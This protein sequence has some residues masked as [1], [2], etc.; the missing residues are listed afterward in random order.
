MHI[1]GFSGDEET[2]LDDLVQHAAIFGTGGSGKTGLSIAIAEEA[3]LAGVPV[4]AID[5]HGDLSNL[6]LVFE[7]L[8]GE[9]I[10]E[11]IE[12]LAYDS[13]DEAAA[14]W[15]SALEAEHLDARLPQLCK[16]PRLI[17]TPA[18]SAGVPLNTVAS[19]AAPAH[20]D[21]DLEADIMLNGL[22][23]LVGLEPEMTSPEYAVCSQ[24]LQ[25]NWALGKSVDLEKLIVQLID[26]PFVKSGT[27][28]VDSFFPPARRRKLAFAFNGLLASISY[29]NLSSGRGFDPEEIL[30]SVGSPRGAVV[31]VGHLSED[32]RQFAV[33]RIIADVTSWMH[34]QGAS[35]TLRLLVVI[36]GASEYVP[37]VSAPAAKDEVERL[38]KTGR[39]FGVGVVLSSSNPYELDHTVIGNCGTWFIGR[40]NQDRDLDHISSTTGIAKADLRGRVQSLD[41]REF[42][43]RRV[44]SSDLVAMRSR[45]TLS[46]LVGPL[47]RPQIRKIFQQNLAAQPAEQREEAE[48][49]PPAVSE[50]EETVIA[51]SEGLPDLP[52]RFAFGEWVTRFEGDPKGDRLSPAL[53]V[54]SALRWDRDNIDLD[55]IE[56]IHVV[57]FPMSSESVHVLNELGG[58]K[59]TLGDIDTEQMG[60]DDDVVSAMIDKALDQLRTIT[61]RQLAFAPDLRIWARPGE[62]LPDFKNRCRVSAVRAAG[63]EVRELRAQ[64]DRQTTDALDRLAD[65]T[66]YDDGTDVAEL[67]QH[68]L[69]VVTELRQSSNNHDGIADE[70]EADWMQMSDHVETRTLTLDQDHEL[71]SVPWILWIPTKTLMM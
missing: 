23:Q 34:R 67:R 61:A 5:T 15:R 26:P 12:R 2:N 59:A 32:V 36:D 27:V 17:Y 21:T 20:D 30:G 37:S 13:A 69:T 35:S 10:E 56:R 33:S 55:L 52:E 71:E 70:I 1:G 18:S 16:V 8:G 9:D 25:H 65:L 14:S 62:S 39:G 38:V 31:S 60:L 58:M 64:L 28:A 57:R 53:V 44:D 48:V 11:Y 19:F 6:A 51:T 54:S 50:P 3:L 42:L 7:S 47:A 63:A 4:L 68:L 41:D 29:Q 22:F 43:V 66:E 45:T 46:F 24:I 40:L 49:S